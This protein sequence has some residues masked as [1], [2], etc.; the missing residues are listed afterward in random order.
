MDF[1]PVRKITVSTGII[2]SVAG[3]GY[4][5]NT[6]SNV[7][8][9]STSLNGPSDVAL[10]KSD[11]IYIAD[12]GNSQVHKVIASTGIITTIAGIGYGQLFGPLINGGVATKFPMASPSGVAVDSA[13]N[14]YIAGGL[15]DSCIF[16]LTLSTGNISIVAGTGPSVGKLVY[17]GDNIPATDATL[18][19]PTNLALD[20]S[21]NIYISDMFHYRIRKVTVSTGII[22]T[23]AGTGKNASE[24]YQGEGGSATSTAIGYPAGLVVDAVGNF[25]FCDFILNVV[26]KVTYTDGSPSASVTPAPT[27]T[28][29]PST[30]TAPTPSASSPS[31]PSVS[32]APAA[33]PSTPSTATAPTPTVVS[34][35]SSPSVS[36][37]PAVTPSA[38]SPSSSSSSA[39]ATSSNVGSQNSSTTHV[40]QTLHVTMI[41]LSSLSILY[42]C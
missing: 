8:A 33:T 32:K 5:G 17:N 18:H 13:G 9:T 26:K 31:S 10:D 27:A 6:K 41:L 7:A 14:V 21:G 22:T 24:P 2:T 28:R 19:A 3:N 1:H 12:R 4:K 37:A 34:S 39:P 40:A 36:K 15:F 30:A 25:Y 42:L 35:P 23:V 20:A 38:S 11:N 16:R 29:A